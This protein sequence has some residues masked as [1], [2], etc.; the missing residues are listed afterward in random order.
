VR[1]SGQEDEETSSE[2]DAHGPVVPGLKQ[3]DVVKS[4]D[5]VDDLLSSLGF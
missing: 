4:Q 3:S 2:G 1:L 5:E